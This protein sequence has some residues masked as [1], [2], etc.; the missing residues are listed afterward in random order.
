MRKYFALTILLAI[1][2]SL[3]ACAPTPTPLPPTATPVPPTATP[4]PPTATAVPPTA[5]PLPTATSI[6][7]TP[8][9]VTQ[10]ITD[11]V[12]R[13]VTVKGVPQRIVSL[14][15][16]NT[17]VLY[18][19]GLGARVVGVTEFCNYPPEAKEKPKIGGF[20]KI[21]LE[22]V[23]GLNP[24]LVLATNIHA[25]SVVPELEKRGITVVVIEPK[26]VDEV[27]AKVTFVGKLTGATETAAKVAAQ[28]QARIDAV[29]SKVAT[30]KSKP[31]V[32]YE[33]DKTLFTA[34]PGSFINDMIVKAGGINI[35]ADAKTAYPQLTAEAIIAKDP[36][37]ILLGSMNFGE[38]PEVVR[39]RPGWANIT[40][41][42]TGRLVPITNEEVISRPGPRVVEG[43][44]LIARAL[45]PDLF[46]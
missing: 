5:T 3:L 1:L 37:V 20:S 25:K 45:Y 14:A 43:L 7:P 6:P 18:A 40:A 46:K 2:M 35:A 31:R 15:P 23:V 41:V 13:T 21:D 38:T 4:I 44:E 27:L 34:G 42:K 26:S 28:M 39:A 17:E 30:V 16:S 29:T 9:L 33:I 11:D 24:D 32:Y 12:G 36:E 8:T 22:R 10:T 19:L